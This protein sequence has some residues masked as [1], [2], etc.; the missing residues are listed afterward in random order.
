[1]AGYTKLWS[2]IVHSTVWQE[3][4]STKV[5][6]ITMLA[7]C[8]SRGY[9][10]ASIPGL[11]HLAGVS[12][13]ECEAALAAFLAPD[14]YSR[15]QEH[16][17]RRI[18]VEEGGW[19]ILNYE[20]HREG[21][22]DEERR[23]LN[24]ESQRRSRARRAKAAENEPPDPP[25]VTGNVTKTRDKSARSLQAEAE[26]E[27]VSP[28]PPTSAAVGLPDTY[29]SDLQAA[30][31]SAQYPEVL[32]TLLRTLTSGKHPQMPQV[33]PEDVGEGLR[34]CLLDRASAAKLTRY[35]HTA[36]KRRTDPFPDAKPR[37]PRGKPDPLGAAQTWVSKE[38]AA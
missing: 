25:P 20:K 31:R 37:T 23:T 12:I 3:S 2:S 14:P 28:S 33:S 5:T 32:C 13:P 19:R 22:A 1:M 18:T 8:D 29:A 34:A 17:G 4:L 7:L 30:L 11:A 9:V 21:V 15:T 10:G 16:E 24:R 35:V 27:A 38:D 36:F 26:A 6:W